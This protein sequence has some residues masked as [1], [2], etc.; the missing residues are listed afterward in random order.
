VLSAGWFKAYVAVSHTEA[1]VNVIAGFLWTGHSGTGPRLPTV[2][3]CGEWTCD[4]T[5]NW[6]NEDENLSKLIYLLC[7]SDTLMDSSNV[8]FPAAEGLAWE[9]CAT[10]LIDTPGPVWPVAGSG[11]CCCRHGAR[12]AGG[13]VK[14]GRGP[15]DG[16]GRWHGCCLDS[17]C[18]RRKYLPDAY[19]VIWVSL[20]KRRLLLL[21][22]G[23]AN[24]RWECKWIV[25]E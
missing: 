13:R 6:Q 14:R 12:W 15:V 18:V 5:R 2:A 24:E 17:A 20:N 3:P 23:D 16:V 9:H 8:T 11:Y 19:K 22:T 21:L 1:C 4:S 25:Q 10:W 7:V